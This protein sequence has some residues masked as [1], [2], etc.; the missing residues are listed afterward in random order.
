MGTAKLTAK[1]TIAVTDKDG[2]VAELKAK[3]IIIATGASTAVPAA[4]KV[5]G[6]KVVTYLEAIL[7][8]K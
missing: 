1:D 8:E 2:K 7:Q 6:E 3:N 4:W 5:D